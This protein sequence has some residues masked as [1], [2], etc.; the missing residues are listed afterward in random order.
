M[1]SIFDNTPA[2]G[3]Y[4]LVCGRSVLQADDGAP[5]LDTAEKGIPSVGS[6]ALPGQVSEELV[7]WNGPDD[8]ENPH[9][10]SSF[11]YEVNTAAI[12]R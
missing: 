12:C 6:T 8:P 10:W 1:P 7:D 9:N 4:E 2:T 5:T 11:K 3:V